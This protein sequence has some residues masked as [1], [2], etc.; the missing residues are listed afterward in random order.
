MTQSA[1]AHTH[2]LLKKWRDELTFLPGKASNDTK[3]PNSMW[4]RS[5]RP[6][7]LCASSL[8]S[9]LHFYFPSFL[10]AFFP[11]SLTPTPESQ[12][13]KIVGLSIHIVI[14]LVS[15][16]FD[17]NCSWGFPGGTVVKGPQAKEHEQP[18]EAE[19]GREADCSLLPP[20]GMQP[21]PQFY[22]K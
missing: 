22:S 14:S 9:P 17:A 20:E 4:P 18:L 12:P 11:T 19:K 1:G 2:T 8:G 13:D 3:L 15:M 7:P 5:M 16:H 6:F 21:T 10:C